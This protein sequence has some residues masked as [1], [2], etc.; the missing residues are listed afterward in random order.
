MELVV[1]SEQQIATR[2]GRMER[3]QLAVAAVNMRAMG[4]SNRI[5]SEVS[6]DISGILVEA[7]HINDNLQ[8]IDETL[9]GGFEQVVSSLDSGFHATVEALRAVAN[10]LHENQK[11]LATISETLSHRYSAEA[12]E[13]L[14]EGQKWLEE[15]ATSD[16]L[17]E[18][19]TFE[20]RKALDYWETAL[21]RFNDVVANKVGEQNYMAWFNIGW[22]RW[23]LRAERHEGDRSVLMELF[24][25]A[26]K[27]F[28]TAQLYSAPKRDLLHTKALRH[29]AE[30]QYLQGKYDEA[31]QTVQRALTVNREYETIYNAARYAAK[32]GRK[33][34][35]VACLDE[36]IELRPGTIQAMFSE[37]DFWE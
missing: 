16:E 4:E 25:D 34:E 6:G 23:K 12:K 28:Y 7:Q 9:V 5:L 31:W 8:R 24:Q 3:N 29:M 21:K 22:L 30:M 32:L 15:G 33:K 19:D 37:E 1:K 14:A 11:T 18:S 10:L 27:A 20:A 35:L 13:L 17:K 2:L 26:E 36:C